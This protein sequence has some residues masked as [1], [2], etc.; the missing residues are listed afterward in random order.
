SE[1][2][3]FQENS[4]PMTYGVNEF[5]SI[6]VYSPALTN[7]EVAQEV[8]KSY[9]PLFRESSGIPNY[10]GEDLPTEAMVK[11]LAV[12][13]D[14]ESKERAGMFYNSFEL[15]KNETSNRFG[16]RKVVKP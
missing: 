14:F 12:G 6:K 15:D 9:V 7:E 4:V 2:F 8:A 10:L 5:G 13:G 3:Y 1:G 11:V 16:V